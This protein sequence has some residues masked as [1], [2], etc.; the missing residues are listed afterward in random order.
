LGYPGGPAIDKAARDGNPHAIEFPRAYLEEDSYD[1][2]F[3]GLKSAVLNYLNSAN[4]KGETININDIAAS[5][6]MAVVE[7]LVNKTVDAAKKN[8]IKKIC[9]SGGVGRNSLLRE[10]LQKVAK[11]EDLQVYFP[12]AD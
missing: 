10:S 9:L 11:D 2:S 6:Q 1:F 4:M 12:E 7:V 8:N 3:S 5:F